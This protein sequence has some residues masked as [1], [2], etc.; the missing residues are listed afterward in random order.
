MGSNLYLYPVQI[1]KYSHSENGEGPFHLYP[2]QIYKYSHSENGEGPFYLY[3]VQIYTYSH[4][5]N[6]EGFRV[7][8]S[9]LSAVAG[10]RHT[11]QK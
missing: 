5:A 3:P 4:T 9:S 8:L 7:F 2:V 10:C 1:Y 11:S 6:R